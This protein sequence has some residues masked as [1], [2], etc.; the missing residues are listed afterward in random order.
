MSKLFLSKI[1]DA[2]LIDFIIQ[3]IVQ[4]SNLII[5]QSSQLPSFYFQNQIVTATGS[6][7]SNPDQMATNGII[8]VID[9]VMFPIPVEDIVTAVSKTP[10]FSTL[11]KAVEVAGLVKALQ[12]NIN[13]F[14]CS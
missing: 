6:P 1:V 5:N 13:S 3:S 8:H 11:L 14:I 10:M 2:R 4:Y 12:G 7:V 9:R